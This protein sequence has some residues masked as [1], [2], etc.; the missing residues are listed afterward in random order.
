M[1]CHQ[2]VSNQGPEKNK[3]THG[4]AVIIPFKVVPFR[5]HTLVPAVLPLSEALW[6]LTLWKSLQLHHHFSFYLLHVL[7]PIPFN[8]IFTSRNRK[9][10]YGAMSSE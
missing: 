8:S 1:P 10:S 4:V 9:Y 5:C 7:K 2:K 3:L 6:A